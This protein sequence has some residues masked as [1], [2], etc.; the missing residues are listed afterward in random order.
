MGEPRNNTLFLL[1]DSWAA[2][3]SWAVKQNPYS[4][5]LSCEIYKFLLYEKLITEK[6]VSDS[7]RHTP[8]GWWRCVL[9]FP[10]NCDNDS[11]AF[12]PV[13][14]DVATRSAKLL[15]P[16]GS[17]ICDETNMNGNASPSDK[18]KPPQLRIAE[19]TIFNTL[20]NAVPAAAAAAT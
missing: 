14:N 13:Q 17:L 10:C 8:S 2:L 3:K 12:P 7:L 16:K 1:W 4:F 11:F 9:A 6:L 19:G 15:D 5:Q 20:I 18:L